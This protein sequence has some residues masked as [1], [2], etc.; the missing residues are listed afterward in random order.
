MAKANKK[1][2]QVRI[3]DIVISGRIHFFN[4]KTDEEQRNKR[5]FYYQESKKLIKKECFLRPNTHHPKKDKRINK[6]QQIQRGKDTVK[7]WQP[8]HLVF[9]GGE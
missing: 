9:S 6:D 5:K 1:A 8:E 2:R 3:F 7:S 4:R